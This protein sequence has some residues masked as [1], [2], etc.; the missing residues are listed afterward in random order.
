M[1][2]G[3]FSHRSSS[4]QDSRPA[5]LLQSAPTATCKYPHYGYEWMQK[6]VQQDYPKSPQRSWRACRPSTAQRRPCLPI[7]GVRYGGWG[8]RWLPSPAESAVLCHTCRPS[9]L[10]T[11]SGHRLPPVELQARDQK[12]AEGREQT[13]RPLVLV[14][15]HFHPPRLSYGLV[16]SLLGVKVQARLGRDYLHF[17]LASLLRSAPSLLRSLLAL[18]IAARCPAAGPTLISSAAI[19]GSL[20]LATLPEVTR[21]TRNLPSG[22]EGR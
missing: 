18:L 10:I 22:A 5:H 3:R 7:C 2:A 19:R 14:C 4:P 8:R 20:T 6:D 16:D 11:Q 15:P 1:R 13:Y 17:H 12:E 21:T 9:A